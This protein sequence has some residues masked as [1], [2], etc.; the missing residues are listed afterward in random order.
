MGCGR[1]RPNVRPVFGGNILDYP[2]TYYMTALTNAPPWNPRFTR[3]N[4]RA[5]DP[6]ATEPGGDPFPISYGLKVSRDVT[7]PLYALVNAMDYDAPN[8]Q[9]AQWN[10]SLQK[11]VGADWLVSVSYL[12]N[13]TTHLFSTQHINPAVYIPGGPCTLN[14]VTYNPCS[15][16]GNI[17]QRRLFSLENPQVGQN[18]GY[19]N[20]IDTG[21]TANYNGLILSLQWRAARGITVSGN[22]TWSHC[23]SD[24]GGDASTS[25]G[26]GNGGWTNP[27]NRRFDRGNCTTA[28]TDRRHVFNLSGVAET[29]RFSNATVRTL[30][31]GWRFSP[32]FKI[33][34]GDYM[35]ITTSQ[36]RALN[37]IGSQRVDQLQADPYGDKSTKGYLNPSAFALPALG[38]LGNS[39]QGSIVGPGTWQFDAAISDHS[40]FVKRRG[41]IRSRGV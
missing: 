31:S 14:G 36:D 35:S 23:I 37:G 27:D 22:Y 34:S 24:P 17:S 20:R 30:A 10:L 6:W 40:S 11:Q 39:G 32:I 12:G 28:G 26:S 8:M 21:G 3:F 41:W 7:W 29:P 1:Q 16:T 33:I 5:E 18:F 19:V 4:V 38:T 9:V 15:S 25:L 2:S 13:Q